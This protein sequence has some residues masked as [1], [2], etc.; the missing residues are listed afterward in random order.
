MITQ[1]TVLLSIQ[2]KWCAKI[3]SGVKTIEI[4]KKTPKLNTPFKCYIYCTKGDPTDPHQRLEVHSPDGKIRP[5]NG[6]VIGEFVCDE[7]FPIRVF[8]NGSIQ[9]W[10]RYDTENAC[11]PYEDVA[12]YIGANKTGFGLHISDM[13]LYDD[14]KELSEFYA[15]DTCPYHGD[16]GCTYPYHCFRAGQLLRCGGGRLSR[17]PQSWQYVCARSKSANVK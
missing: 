15:A 10:N 16:D 11:V 5:A 3:A 7:F 6:K 2:P 17:P 4:R 1:K 14:P 13:L 8:D 12:E 9:D